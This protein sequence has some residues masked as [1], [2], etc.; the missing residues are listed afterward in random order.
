[1]IT[2]VFSVIFIIIISLL[3]H[4]SLRFGA[5]HYMSEEGGLYS[6]GASQGETQPQE[7]Q[8]VISY[9]VRVHT[10][11]NAPTGLSRSKSIAES[12]VVIALFESRAAVKHILNPCFSVPDLLKE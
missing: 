7:D 4:L 1:M 5:E 11:N 2:D 10:E 12:F 9:D 3:F 6:S 8:S